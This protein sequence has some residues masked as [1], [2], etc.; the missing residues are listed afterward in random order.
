MITSSDFIWVDQFATEAPKFRGELL[1]LK[2]FLS[3]RKLE[4]FTRLLMA[5]ARPP[6]SWKSAVISHESGPGAE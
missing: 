4:L 2:S 3:R 5:I 6:F 1:K